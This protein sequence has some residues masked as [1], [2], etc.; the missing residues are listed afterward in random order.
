MLRRLPALLAVAFAAC[1]GGSLA[2]RMSDNSPSPAP[3]VLGC[4]RAQLKSLGFTESSFDSD[5]LRVTARKFDE[6]QRRPDTQFRRMVDRLAIEVGPASDGAV[7]AITVDASTFAEMTTQR[8]PTEVQ[9]KASETARGAA[10]TLIQK[11]S[12][13]VDSLSVPG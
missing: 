12:Q 4:A 1:L 8:G 10:Q 9:E 13:P 2:T 3:D 6:T 7:T 11:C 5:R